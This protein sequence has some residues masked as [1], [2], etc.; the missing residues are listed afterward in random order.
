MPPSPGPQA[1]SVVAGWA[2]HGKPAK[3]HLGFNKSILPFIFTG[4]AL[5]IPMLFIRHFLFQLSETSLSYCFA[6]QPFHILCH[7]RG[8]PALP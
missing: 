8:L 5:W 2:M 1:S 7:A 3:N 4:S 6:G